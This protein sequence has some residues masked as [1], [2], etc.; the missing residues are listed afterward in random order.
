M[1]LITLRQYAEDQGIS[2][3]AVR[4]KVVKYTEELSGHIV[5]KGRV[6]YLD[7]KA[8][9]FL[10]NKRRENPVVL[11]KENQNEEIEALRNQVD[12]LKTQLLTMQHELLE[13]KDRIIA[14]QDEAKQNIE[15]KTK[16]EALVAENEKCNSEMKQLRMENEQLVQEKETAIAEA[17]SYHKS[18][19]GFYRKK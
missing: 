6:Q 14:L 9:E 19:L 11:V 16:Y 7:P 17:N 12:S 2:Y 10:K 1:E 18:I 13:S 5:K 8:V 4:K 3:E 15:D